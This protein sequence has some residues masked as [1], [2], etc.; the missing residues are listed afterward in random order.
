[1][2]NHGIFQYSDNLSFSIYNVENVSACNISKSTLKRFSTLVSQQINQ[3]FSARNP[4]EPTTHES[5]S[6]PAIWI[7]LPF[8]GK[9]G[10]SLVRSCTRK[11]SRLIKKPVKFVT[12]WH[13]VN[14][15]TFTTQKDPL[16]PN[17]TRILS[18]TN[19]HAQHGCC[20]SYIGKF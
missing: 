18:C 10:C 8:I 2:I 16:Y 12:L 11:I 13:T 9:K 3:T 1:M 20:S 17:L 6:I 19:S 14:A 15:S 5:E 7:K 4:N